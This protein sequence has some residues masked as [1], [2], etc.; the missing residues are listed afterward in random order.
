MRIRAKDILDMLAGG[1]SDADIL[2]D[3]PDLER[4]D[5]D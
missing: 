4:A 5:L 1:A 3:F 2:A